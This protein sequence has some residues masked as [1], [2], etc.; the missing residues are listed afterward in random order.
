MQAA[1]YA[2]SELD[3][4]AGADGVRKLLRPTDITVPLLPPSS[5][6]GQPPASFPKDGPPKAASSAA[7]PLHPPVKKAKGGA[8]AGRPSASGAAR[9]SGPIAATAFRPHTFLAGEF[10]ITVGLGLP[11]RPSGLEQVF[12]VE[13]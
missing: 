10:F 5:A 12:Q 2:Y 3:R 4:S 6:A 11:L 1:T 9:A 13:V 7:P 8:G